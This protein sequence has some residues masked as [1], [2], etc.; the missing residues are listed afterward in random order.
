MSIVSIP[1]RIRSLKRL[2]QIV[3]VALKYGFGDVVARAG[4]DTVLH[5]VKSVVIPDGDALVADRRTEERIRLL[6]EELGPTFVKLGQV[7]AT[8][9]D[10]IPLELVEELRKLQDKV[11]PFDT[12]GIQALVEEELG[13]PVSEIFSEF[14][15]KPLA[16]ASIAQVHRATLKD[17]RKVVL[18]IQRPNLERVIET[19]LAILKWLAA[20]AEE[21]LPE[22]RRYSP[23]G[24]V[25]EFEKSLMKEIDF[26][27]EAYHM[28]RF[29]KN[30]AG[31]PDIYVPEVYS[32][33]SS[34]RILCEEFIDGTPAND[35]K[36]HDWPEDV[37]RKLAQAGI[38]LMLEQ[39]LVH[40][41]FH[42][43][44][45]PGNIFIL[46]D[47]RICLIDYGMMGALDQ[48]RI[49]ELLTFLVAILT[50]DLDK[51]IRLF[52]KLELIGESTDV[53]LLRREI[54]DLIARFES[55]E[56]AQLNIGRYLNSVFEVVV[57][58]DV[59]IPSDLLMVGKGLATIEGVGRDLYPELNTLEEIRP[60]IIKIYLGR[61]TDPGYYTR[62]PRRV[63]EDLLSLLETGP[64]DLR[65]SLKKLREG[66]LQTRLELV[67]FEKARRSQAQAS[68][69]LALALVIASLVLASAYV[70]TQ[71]THAEIV[72]YTGEVPLN[73]LLALFGFG[74]AALYGAVLTIGFLRSGAF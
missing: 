14:E 54:D 45:H 43:D 73:A 23:S 16:A 35:P 1:T 66:D 52:N 40:G 69:R 32:E 50:R 65:L 55:V 13:R 41:F 6:L 56:L 2:P 21:N 5:R 63:T 49:D 37:R 42:G 22:L 59:Q 8:R 31:D 67:D 64:R 34:S 60:I 33:W 26:E 15:S 62:T 24:L 20:A 29:A 36:I 51:L 70:W 44:P 58:H 53:R 17:G 4:L 48:E 27:T 57:R 30:F 61:L 68:N 28:R 46:P 19:D 11:K 72:A 47:K 3:S 18:K 71:G 25:S 10:L 39:A 38:R 12:E 74:L 7:M 9:P